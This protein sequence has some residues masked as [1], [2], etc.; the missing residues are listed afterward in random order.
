MLLFSVDGMWGRWG[1]WSTCS[2]TCG[3]GGLMTRER[4][5]ADPE[6]AHGGRNCDWD[7]RDVGTGTCNETACPGEIAKFDLINMLNVI[8][9]L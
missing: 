4:F 1:N 6:P 5:C 3:D 8:F 7:N 9:L 2:V